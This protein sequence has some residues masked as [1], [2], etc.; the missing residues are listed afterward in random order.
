MTHT[1]VK[2]LVD[3]DGNTDD[4]SWHVAVLVCGDPAVFCTG[5]Y[6]TYGN[7]SDHVKH[8]TADADDQPVTCPDCIEAINN[9]KGYKVL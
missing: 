9:L 2:M 4:H 7:C 1:V 5:E 8:E 3:H 6:Y